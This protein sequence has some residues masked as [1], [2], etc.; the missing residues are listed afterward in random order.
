MRW[1]LIKATTYL[2][3]IPGTLATTT[4]ALLTTMVVATST[5]VLLGKTGNYCCPITVLVSGIHRS[6]RGRGDS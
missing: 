3:F 4:T 5:T 2:L 6:G 1:I